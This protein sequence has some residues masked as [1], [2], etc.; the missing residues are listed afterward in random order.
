MYKIKS[1]S[2]DPPGL[3]C[4]T[5]IK[6]ETGGLLNYENFVDLRKK[7]NSDKRSW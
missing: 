3:T 2:P 7:S 1:A 4:H 5:G 6:K